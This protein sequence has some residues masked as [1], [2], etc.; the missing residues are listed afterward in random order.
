MKSSE[1]REKF[2]TFFKDKGHTVVPSSALLPEGD[3]TL[4]FTNAG[5]VQFKGVFLEEEKRDYVRAATSQRCLRAGGKHNDLENVGVTARHHT[6]FEMLGNF[7]FGDYFKE[8]AIEYAWEFLV[9]VMGLPEDK[10]YATVFE[11]DDEA[12]ALWL[13][14][15]GVPRERVI[16]LGEADN[17]W[18]MGD[19]GPCGPCSE[20]LIDQG[21]EL[22][23]N[24]P[25]C[26]PGCDCDRYLEIW[27]L[28][29]MQFNRT[30]DGAQHPLPKPSIDTGMG[31]E[32]LSSVMQGKKSNYDTDLFEP[33]LKSIEGLTGLKYGTDP[34]KDVSFKAIA[35]HSRAI[36]FLISDGVLP[37]NEGRGY[38]LRRII[39]RAARHGRYLGLEEPFIYKVNEAVIDLMGI[40]YGEIVTGKDIITMA[41]RSEEERFFETLERGLT[42]LGEEVSKVKGEG[43]DQIPGDVAFKLYDTFGFPVDLT[44]DIIKRENLT[45]DEAGFES[46]M[47]NQRDSSREARKGGGD[48]GDT[49]RYRKLLERGIKSAFRG[50]SLA[51]EPTTSKVTSILGSDGPV[52]KAGA[53]DEIR[54][55]T[56]ET[57]FYGESGGQSGDRGVIET[58]TGALL[59]VRDTKKPLPDLLVHTCMVDKGEVSVGDEAILKPDSDERIST[60]RN[61]TA[62]HLLHAALREVLGDHVRQA[63]SLV[64]GSSLRFDFNH[65]QKVTPEELREVENLANRAVLD[66]ME[67]LTEEVPYNE[68]IER[69]ALAFFGDK[70]GERVRMVKVEDFSTELCGGTHVGRTGDIGMIKITSE[71]SIAAGVRRVEA[72]TG[73][74]SIREVQD[75]ARALK[76]TAAIL[77][78]ATG[79]VSEKIQKLL[80]DNKRLE[81]MVDSLKSQAKAGTASTLTDKVVE[82]C[83]VNLLAVQVDVEGAGDLREIGDSLKAKLKSGIIILAAADKEKGKVLLLAVVTKDL[84][85]RFSAGEIVK[86]LAPIVGGRGGGKAE[87]AQ[88]GGGDTEKVEELLKAAPGV[89]ESL[90]E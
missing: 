45:V 39:R 22:S 57:T 5:M 2:L 77:K 82:V 47:K 58:G 41:T 84:T 61:H 66:N 26:A 27:N 34:E 44:A 43:G 53:G 55:I 60:A 86:S 90:I 36:T 88:A 76:E 21:E 68:A 67:V 52:E 28:V 64:G 1:I 78:V 48:E 63:G 32:R 33:I 56:E 71:S 16:R 19:V 72:I 6:F 85:G 30:A 37:S 8:E 17:F 79:E 10:L 18:S 83:G 7:S 46:H 75:E 51:S 25:T 3:A 31:L 59:T 9:Q 50:Y 15:I 74:K 80:A 24:K 69:G 29:F 54:I 12:E 11:D 35:D 81:K 14:K 70:Y 42:L 40:H 89:I 62:T 13:N 23:C 20:I 49:D 65:F 87:M 4:L 38:V 73:H